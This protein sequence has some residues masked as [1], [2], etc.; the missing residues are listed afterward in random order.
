MPESQFF[1]ISR[2]ACAAEFL[3]R[4]V[5]KRGMEGKSVVVIG[6]GPS[7]ITAARLIKEQGVKDVT[8]VEACAHTGGRVYTNVVDAD[9]EVRAFSA[10]MKPLELGPEFLHGEENNIFFDWI[11]KHG[12]SGKPEVTTLQLAWPNYLYFGKE[13]KLVS[14]KDSEN[15]EE[16]QTMLEVFEMTEGLDPNLIPEETLLQ[17]MVRM[18]TPSRMID[19][20]DAIFANDY[21]AEMS[22][23]GLKETAHEQQEWNYGEDY[24]VLDGCNYSDILADMAKGLP[25]RHNW[26]VASID[27]GRADGRVAVTNNRGETIVAD[28]VVSTVPVSCLRDRDISFSPPLPEGKQAAAGKIKIGNAVKAVCRLDTKFWPDDLWDVV[29]S[30]SFMPELWLTPAADVL[31][32]AAQGKPMKHYF[33]VGFVSGERADRVMQLPK[34]EVKRLMLLQLDA[35]FGTK[36]NPHP[37]SSSCSGFMVQD[38]G[39]SHFFR[40]A[41]PPTVASHD[42]RSEPRQTS[43]PRVGAYT[44][45]SPGAFGERGVLG[46]PV[47][48][49]LFFAGEATQTGCNPC[50]QAAMETGARAAKEVAASLG[51]PR[52]KL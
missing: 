1:G 34:E 49:K 23:I 24:L 50:L 45:P 46:A 10:G 52:P 16:F 44:Y 3:P 36:G 7:G 27:H 9:P 31:K 28:R 19:M 4:V 14:G 39:K 2:I 47:G 17:Y 29:C 12:V 30:D 6:A 13:G 42:A 40:G 18:G 43:S 8:I 35:I 51:A 25:I 5:S 48:G 21:G 41:P 32:S 11:K 33:M 38:W 15:I 22:K 26:V 20:A 37:A